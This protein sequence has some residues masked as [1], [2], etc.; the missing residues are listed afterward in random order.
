MSI[1]G[2]LITREFFPEYLGRE[3]L[4]NNGRCYK[5][6][7]IA[8]RLYSDVMIWS[9]MSHAFVEIDGLFYDAESPNGVLELESLNCNHRRGIDRDDSWV[10]TLEELVEYWEDHGKT[11][12]DNVDELEKKI[13][14]F[15]ECN[16]WQ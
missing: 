9:N 3:E 1:D 4:I 14:Y 16:N 12:F 15:C 10:Q 5:W 7:Y 2:R 11:G 8:A 13:E 6:A